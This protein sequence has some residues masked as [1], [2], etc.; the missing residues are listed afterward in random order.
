MVRVKKI[1]G[2]IFLFFIFLIAGTFLAKDFILKEILERK[3][4]KI[5]NAPVTIQ[6]VHLSPFDNYI[7]VENIK[8][9]STLN[10]ENIFIS[11]DELK[12]YYSVDYLNKVVSFNDTEISNITFFEEEGTSVE[13]KY[14]SKSDIF[15]NKISEAEKSYKKDKVLTE[16]KNLYLEKID[17]DS[18]KIDAAIREKYSKLQFVHEQI[19]NVT[20]S[21]SF[22]SIKESF[23]K[24][25]D[26]KKNK[27]NLAEILSEL[28]NIGKN[29][30][31]VTRNLD[32]NALK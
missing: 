23:K 14:S 22:D 11:I 19:D 18:E 12:S 16:L 7:T 17:I 4:S 29:S 20:N 3:L 21:E 2:F 15:D 24:I 10:S 5:N 6:R 31:E 32:L 13:Q 30:R 8:I 9:S 26:I 27:D 25:K 1:I 28:S